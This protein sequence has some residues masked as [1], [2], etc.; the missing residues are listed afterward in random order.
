M[1]LSLRI[2]SDVANAIMPGSIKCISA[3]SSKAIVG[4]TLA[5]TIA[6]NVSIGPTRP[7]VPIPEPVAETVLF[8]F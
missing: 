5:E 2:A 1:I 3:I 7:A 4:L 6:L 8:D